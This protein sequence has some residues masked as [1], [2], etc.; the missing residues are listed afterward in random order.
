MYFYNHLI[1][2][3]YKFIIYTI[4]VVAKV[5][6][7]LKAKQNRN[8]NNRMYFFVQLFLQ[9]LTTFLENNVSLVH[10]GNKQKA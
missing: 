1:H 6:K 4:E 2:H 3:R 7:V 10:F 5:L 9:N 8:F